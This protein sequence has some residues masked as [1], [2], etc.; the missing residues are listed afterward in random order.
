MRNTSMGRCEA[1]VLGITSPRRS[2]MPKDA[3]V[4]N[5]ELSKVLRPVLRVEATESVEKVLRQLRYRQLHMAAV[6]NSDDRLV[7]LVTVE[8]LLEEIVGEIVDEHDAVQAGESD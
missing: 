5:V 3:A 8:D 2:K 4:A 1:T 7:G 6:Y